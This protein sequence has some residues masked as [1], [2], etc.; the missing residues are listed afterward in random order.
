MNG[1]SWENRLRDYEEKY[2][3][4]WGRGGRSGI[5]TGV[6]GGSESLEKLS[7]KERTAR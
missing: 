1:D 2:L 6:C 5:Q 4:V 7:I 3:P